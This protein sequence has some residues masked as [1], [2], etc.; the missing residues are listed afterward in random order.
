MAATTTMTFR[1][2]RFGG[3]FAGCSALVAFRTAVTAWRKL[4]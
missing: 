3:G 2:R 4:R 1:L